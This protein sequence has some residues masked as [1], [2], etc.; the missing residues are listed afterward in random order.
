MASCPFN[1]LRRL[2]SKQWCF[3][4]TTLSSFILVLYKNRRCVSMIMM[5]GFGRQ[6]TE[7]CAKFCFHNHFHNILRLFDVLPWYI[8]VA[9]RV[10]ER[11]KTQD[12]RKLGNIRKSV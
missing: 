9:S 1:L 5:S 8:L 2:P 4:I 3:W 7:K 11:F 10:A 6:L 12:L